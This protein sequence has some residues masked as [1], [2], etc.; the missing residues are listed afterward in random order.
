MTTTTE[1]PE[2][3]TGNRPAARELRRSADDRMLGGVVGGL[4]RYLD[5]DATL[6]RVVFAALTIMGGAGVALYAAGWLLI[7]EDGAEQSIA[8][9]YL[10]SHRSR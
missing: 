2:A 9:S 6:L 8:A 5:V 7:P 4:A 1:N 3:T 10:G